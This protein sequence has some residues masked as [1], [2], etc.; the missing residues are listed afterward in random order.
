MILLVNS[1]ILCMA[2]RGLDPEVGR[3]L[4]TPSARFCMAFH[5]ILDATAVRWC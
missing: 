2:Y 1:S 3:C 5:K 4:K